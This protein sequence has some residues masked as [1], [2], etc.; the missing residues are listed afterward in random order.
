MAEY[1]YPGAELELFAG[2]TRW[3]RYLRSQ[4][5]PYLRG[6]VLEVGAGIGGTTDVLLS[7][8]AQT[9]TCL[10]PDADLHARLA[11]AVPV[12]AA[13]E[14]VSARALRGV[15]SDL[16]A[17]SSF[18]CVLYVDVLEHIDDDHAELARAA[19]RTRAG[20]AIVVMSPAHQWLYSPFD[21][22]VGHCRRYD[23]QRLLEIAPGATLVERV[24]YLDAAGLLASLANRWLLRASLPTAGQI[25]TW[26]TLLVPCS[27]IL[28][29]LLAYR[30]GKSVLAVYR[31][32]LVEVGN[33]VR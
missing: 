33:R 13:R 10:E 2:A 17:S 30:A 1:A 12:Y 21:E 28:D 5:A 23:K 3:K 9:W 29:P 19:A 32:Q 15:V 14:K 20:G 22:H 7:G 27:R 8:T 26:D 25:E 18:D 11:G 31:Q 4:I 6:D 16:P 24:R